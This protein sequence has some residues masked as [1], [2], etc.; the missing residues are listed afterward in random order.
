MD[1]LA[2]GG[3]HSD[4]HGY[5]QHHCGLESGSDGIDAAP[6]DVD[7][8]LS[9]PQDPTT[10]VPGTTRPNAL[11]RTSADALGLSPEWGAAGENSWR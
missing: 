4:H 1:F 3:G 10:T 11:D 2:L 6:G 9:M 7:P 8:M 5:Q